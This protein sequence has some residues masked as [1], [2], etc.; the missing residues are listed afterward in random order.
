MKNNSESA[1]TLTP[2]NEALTIEQLQE[3]IG[4]PIVINE[5]WYYLEKI[6]NGI[7]YCWRWYM[8][9]ADERPLEQYGKTW[10]A[11]RRP[12]ERQEDA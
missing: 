9:F 6:V 1:P 12:L 5:T 4:G 3:Q 8:D 2:P 10:L 11:Y 7:A